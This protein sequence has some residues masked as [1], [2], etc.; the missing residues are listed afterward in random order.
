MTEMESQKIEMF[1]NRHKAKH[2]VLRNKEQ[3]AKF[4]FL[5]L[6]LPLTICYITYTR[7]RFPLL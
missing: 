6:D 4:P 2:I 1:I 3:M 5:G 7:L